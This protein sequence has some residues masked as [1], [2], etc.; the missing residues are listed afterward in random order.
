MLDIVA[1]SYN[2][3]PPVVPV[4]GVIPDEGGTIGRDTE[5]TLSLPDPARLVSRKHG[6]FFR[7]GA[8]Y[9]IANISDGNAFFIG[10]KEVAAGARCPLANGDLLQIGGYVLRIGMP[11]NSALVANLAPPSDAQGTRKPVAEQ[12]QP[13]MPIPA[14]KDNSSPPPLFG[15]PFEDLLAVPA[16]PPRELFR[17]SG[18]G[19]VEQ[20]RPQSLIPADFDP[21]VD[22]VRAVSQ[23]TPEVVG[24]PGKELDVVMPKLSPFALVRDDPVVA[25]GSVD[26]MLSSSLGEDRDLVTGKIST[27]PL[28]LFSDSSRHS[29][30]LDG[31]SEGVSDPM[32]MG[33]CS[34]LSSAF[35]IAAPKVAEPKVAELTV[36][37]T[38]NVVLPVPIVEAEPVACANSG[39]EKSPQ[40]V[41]AVLETENT[42]SS[43]GVGAITKGAATNLLERTESQSAHPVS[44]CLETTNA[45]A[46]DLKALRHALESGLQA[47]LPVDSIVLNAEIMH[48]IGTL[49]RT[50]INGTLELMR[51]RS[52]VKKEVRVE[53]TLIEPSDNNPLKFSPDVDVAIQYMFGRKHPGF[54]GPLEAM[55]EAYVDLASHQMAMVAGMRSAMEDII[56]RFDPERIEAEVKSKTVLARVSNTY[57]RAELWSAYCARYQGIADVLGKDFQDFYAQ[58]FTR[59]Y[60]EE[61]AGRSAEDDAR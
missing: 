25:Q 52:A 35:R 50:A 20:E 54:Q 22:T 45:C 41:V 47:K 3:L 51:A 1:L 59:A 11:G 6:R 29:S 48:L 53:M 37:A 46:P 27:D 30:L 19:H 18:V 13:L 58:A 10:E 32:Q 39:L 44:P 28:D 9:Y 12:S 60:E 16:P 15:G 7:E 23:G 38:N 61:S 55:T 17:S 40:E 8:I 26:S 5:N 42:H 24:E 49:L 36:V 2:E 4:R 21:F 57:G 31:I 33:P 34:D 14:A 56:R 43:D